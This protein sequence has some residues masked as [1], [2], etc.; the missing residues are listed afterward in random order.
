MDAFGHVNNVVYFRWCESVR[1]R[2]LEL[3]G[4][5]D[6]MDAN[7]VGPILAAI[8]CHYRRQ[9]TYPD[10]VLVGSKMLRIGH[11]SMAMQHVLFSEEQQ[12]VVAEGEATIV[13]FD[14]RE[15]RPVEVPESVRQKIARLEQWPASSTGQQNAE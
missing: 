11:S 3:A 9:L 13:A 14:Y 6:M 5:A 12:A 10:Q 8:D 2:Y 4:L 1:V 7:Q 15:Q